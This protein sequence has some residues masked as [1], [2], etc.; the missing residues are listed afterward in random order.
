[1]TARSL[2]SRDRAA[3]AARPIAPMMFIVVVVALAGCGGSGAKNGGG[4]DN[5]DRQDR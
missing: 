4:T 2:C 5:H 1:L 3:V